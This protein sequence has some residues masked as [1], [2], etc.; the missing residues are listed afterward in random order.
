MS[1]VSRIYKATGRAKC[2]LCGSIIKKGQN[3]ILITGYQTECQI[4]SNPKDC[5]CER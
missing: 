4:H 1:L 2:N 5:D 3:A